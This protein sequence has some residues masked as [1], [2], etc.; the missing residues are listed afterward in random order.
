[1]KMEGEEDKKNEL[2]FFYFLSIS[3]DFALKG[4]THYSFL[5]MDSIAVR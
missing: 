2:A 1:M 4:M 3:G 5:F